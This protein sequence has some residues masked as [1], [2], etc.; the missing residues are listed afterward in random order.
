[1]GEKKYQIA[2]YRLRG[3]GLICLCSL[4]FFAG[5]YVTNRKSITASS[6]VDGRRL[7]VSG[8]QTAEKKIALTFD[9]AWAGGQLSV[10]LKILEA[11]GARATFFV[12]GEWAQQHAEDVKAIAAAGC[13][14][15][16]YGQRYEDMSGMAKLEIQTS[17]QQAYDTVQRLTGREIKV[18]RAPYDA[19]SDLLIDTV[20]MSGCMPVRWDVDSED[21]KDYGV[22][23]IIA[24]VTE[25]PQLCN[26]SVVRLRSD[27][28]YLPQALET[29]VMQLQEQGYELAAAGELVLWS[30]YALDAS[31]RQIPVPE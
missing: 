25:Q 2:W 12:T 31:G 7:P 26:G 19:Y 22:E 14:I 21:W 15:G 17:L 24:N 27:A 3:L 28:A 1:M 4:V 11:Y 30:G 23:S 10:I 8:V 5:A 16:T 6:T 13:E 9:T 20:K 29:V 18:F